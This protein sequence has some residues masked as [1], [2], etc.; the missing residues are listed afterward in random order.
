MGAFKWV[1]YITDNKY[2]IGLRGLSRDLK[3]DP[4]DYLIPDA[5]IKRPF[6]L[7]TYREVWKERIKK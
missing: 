4:K 3:V 7:N 6:T 2:Y 1:L 5:Q